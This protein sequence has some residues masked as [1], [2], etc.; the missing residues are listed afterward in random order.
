MNIEEDPDWVA[1][2]TEIHA[3]RYSY[4][5]IARACK[6]SPATIGNAASGKFKLGYTIGVRVMKLRAR[7]LQ[8][9]KG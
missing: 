3:M 7:L 4:S 6:C 1:V 5:R 2:L 8:H 9:H